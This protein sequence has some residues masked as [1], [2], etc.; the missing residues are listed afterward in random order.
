MRDD[1]KD[2][3]GGYTARGNLVKTNLV[4][5][6]DLVP[7]GRIERIV[8]SHVSLAFTGTSAALCV[9][10]TVILPGSV[11]YAVWTII[12]VCIYIYVCNELI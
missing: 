11:G 5:Q 2:G 7:P 12:G 10:G 3:P 1:N 4:G 8:E 6:K 9:Y